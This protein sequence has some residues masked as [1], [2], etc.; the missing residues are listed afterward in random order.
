MTYRC[1]RCGHPVARDANILVWMIGDL[2]GL[3]FAEAFCA[4][5]CLRCGPIPRKEFPAKVRRNML[6]ASA[7]LVLI[8]LVPIAVIV[9]LLVRAHG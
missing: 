9:L 6:L 8:A 7:A 1:P 5:R 2:I 4:F 3:L